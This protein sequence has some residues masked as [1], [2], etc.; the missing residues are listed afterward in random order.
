M[1]LC[2]IIYE[3]LKL[4]ASDKDHFPV[5]DR[6]RSLIFAYLN[7]KVIK[8]REEDTLINDVKPS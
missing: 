4:L 7:S 6:V 8:R 5:R 3:R 1:S 2:T